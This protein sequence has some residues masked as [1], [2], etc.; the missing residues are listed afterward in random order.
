M[1]IIYKNREEYN[2]ADRIQLHN[3][4]VI[5]VANENEYDI[6]KSIYT[7]KATDVDF[8]YLKDLIENPNKTLWK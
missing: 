5:A 7:G 6:V 8:S 3:A 4:E 2:N 1:I